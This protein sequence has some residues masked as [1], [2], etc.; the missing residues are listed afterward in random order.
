[1]ELSYDNPDAVTLTATGQI[2]ITIKQK[3]ELTMEIGQI[4]EEVKC[5]RP[6]ADTGT[7][8]ECW[9]RNGL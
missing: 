9:K 6:F 1:M 2:E 3:S 5:R 8:G 7:A 4:P